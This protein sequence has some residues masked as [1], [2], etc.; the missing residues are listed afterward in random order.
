MK[1]LSL[2]AG[3]AEMY[4][5]SCLRDNT[6][7]RELMAMGHDAVLV[8]VYTPTKV[9][10]RNVSGDRVLFGGISVYLQQHAAFFRHTPWVVDRLLDSQWALK[11]AARRSLA[12]NPTFLG[13]MTV[14]MLEGDSGPLAK[15]F[16]KLEY[17]LSHTQMPDV[18]NLPNALLIAMAHSIKQVFRGPVVCTLQGE[19]LFL[20]GLG[21]PY[22]SHAMQLIRARV[23]DVDAFVAVSEWYSDYMAEYF[24]IPRAKVH[25]VRLG[26]DTT[27]FPVATERSGP[28]TVSYLARVAPEKGLHLLC[29]AWRKFRAMDKGPARLRVAGYLA[30]EHRPY[31]EGVKHQMVQWGHGDD[32]SYVGELEHADKLRFLSESH[33]FTVPATYDDPKG[34]YALE[35]M[36]AGVPVVL[37]RRGALQEH[38]ELTGGGLLAEPDDPQSI[39]EGWLRLKNDPVLAREMGERGRSGVRQHYTV[40][41]MA[42][43]ALGLYQTLTAPQAVSG[44]EGSIAS[45]YKLIER[46]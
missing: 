36:A 24:A 43:R 34:L 38:I 27:G 16:S 2:T 8:P 17:W 18:V 6:L 42:E 10:G 13:Q 15:E 11:L 37:P 39:A 23:K 33:A 44:S 41:R 12:V 25:V 20:D 30:P 21:E 40:R 31:L 5:G 14:S 3:A 35:A 26:I 28:F 45:S 22:K 32:F 46:I 29:D 9:E 19:D 7:A 1:I 4:C